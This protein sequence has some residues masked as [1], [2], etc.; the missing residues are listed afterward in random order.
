MSTLRLRSW[1][2]VLRLM[3][4]ANLIILHSHQIINIPS[5]W[6]HN[7]EMD[8]K[9]H[10]KE[11]PISLPLSFNK[12]VLQHWMCFILVWLLGATENTWK[13]SKLA[14][15]WY[16]LVLLGCIWIRCQI[17]HKQIRNS[18]NLCRC[19]SPN[20]S[21]GSNETWWACRS[22]LVLAMVRIWA[23]PQLNLLRKL[24]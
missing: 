17:S 8:R 4:Q 11:G 13:H 7:S 16:D 6:P 2:I 9:C 18:L 12:D 5:C 20:L 14:S 15:V 23:P 24:F 22:S 19:R 3:Y 1:Y 10:S 21:C